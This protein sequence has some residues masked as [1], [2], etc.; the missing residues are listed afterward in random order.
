MRKT[1]LVLLTI[2]GLMLAGCG[3]AVMP[4]NTQTESGEQFVVALPQIVI[5]FDAAGNPSI[6]GMSLTDAGKMVG[7]DLSGLGI[8][9]M[10]I[11]PQIKLIDSLIAANVQNIELRQTGD[12]VAVVVNGMALPHIAW[13]DTSLQ[14]ATDVAAMFNIQGLDVIKKVLPIVRRLGVNVA[15]RFP[16]APG[17]EAIPLS[18]PNVPLPTPKAD[19]DPASVIAKME[20]KY[21]D[22]GVPSIMGISAR[23]LQAM[24][25]N[26]PLAL[27]PSVIEA[28][29][30][31]NVQSMELSSK[32]DGIFIYANGV[33]LPN[34]SWDN[35][36]LM[37]A[38]ELYGQMNP[39]SPY[40]A[41]VKQFLPAVNNVNI[42]LLLHFP[43]AEG[44]TPIK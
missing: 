14:Q 18:D 19:D 28:L 34:L 43:L 12:G 10:Y 17:V 3:P 2:A 22:Q 7:Q 13:T 30:A 4:Q 37:N 44:A 40:V 36:M 23:D 25:L 32:P 33:A 31:N 21:D 38:A 27:A 35:T 9:N 39:T 6:M 42:D 41:A 24:G 15:L 16:P 29:K 26:M 8:G 20:V 1:L 11:T 5:D